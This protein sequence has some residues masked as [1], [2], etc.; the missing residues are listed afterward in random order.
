MPRLLLGL[1]AS[2]GTRYSRCR[3]ARKYSRKSPK[4]GVRQAGWTRQNSDSKDQPASASEDSHSRA[5][6]DSI[7]PS[8][9]RTDFVAAYLTVES[10]STI[11]FRRLS[12]QRVC[13]VHGHI[14]FRVFQPRAV[15]FIIKKA[16]ILSIRSALFPL[17]A[18]LRRSPLFRWLHDF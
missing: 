8:L 5:L 15:I 9:C 12:T 11:H 4:A 17:V 16:A 6:P 10:P 3:Q 1:S 18:G 2:S 13:L 7:S 14:P